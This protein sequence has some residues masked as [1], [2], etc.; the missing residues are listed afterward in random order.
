MS[1]VQGPSITSNLLQPTAIDAPG[2]AFVEVACGKNHMA[3]ITS[4]GKL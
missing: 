1:N 3:A 2:I 4:G